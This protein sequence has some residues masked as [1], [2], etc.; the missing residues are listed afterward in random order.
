MHYYVDESGNTGASL[1]DLNQP[2]LYYGVLVSKIDLAATIEEKIELI[3]EKLGVERLHAS[4]LGQGRLIHVAKEL[5]NLQSELS[6][7]FDV[8]RVIKS[9]HAVIQFFDQ[10]FDSAMNSGVAWSSYWTVR[11]YIILSDLALLFDNSLRRAA[12]EIR[13]DIQAERA[14]KKLSILCKDLLKRIAR[15]RNEGTRRIIRR[16]LKTAAENPLEIS[17]NI[18][19]RD[20][21]KQISPNIIGFQFVM[22]GIARRTLQYSTAP[23][24]IIVDRQGEFNDAQ[25]VLSELYAKAA[26]VQFAEAPGVMELNFDGMPQIPITFTPGDKNCGLEITDIFLWLFKLFFEKKKI[27]HELQPLINSQMG[28]GNTDELSLDGIKSRISKTF[29]ERPQLFQ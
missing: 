1:F 10:V 26:G 21:I 16:A 25:R 29:A 17:Y 6:L 8:Y 28:I 3:R 12:W 24:Q 11:R 13:I 23:Q 5:Q 18:E 20:A 7:E 9:D 15:I 22:Q 19:S 4:E 2:V 27:A 14:A